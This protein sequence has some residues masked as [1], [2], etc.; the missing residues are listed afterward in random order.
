[1]SAA[2]L[3]QFS[4]TYSSKELD[5]PLVV[6]PDGPRLI[7]RKP[8]SA[9]CPLVAL[10]SDL[11]IGSGMRVRFTR[12]SAAAVSAFLLSGPSVEPRPEFTLRTHGGTVATWDN[13]NGGACARIDPIPCGCS[14]D[15]LE[16]SAEPTGNEVWSLIRL[17]RR[18]GKL[19]NR[20]QATSGSEIM[21]SQR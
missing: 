7:L 14:L 3:L 12:D 9:P 19:Q 18:S 21:R 16:I 13:A 6:T 8:K 11:F 4:G 5:V 20:S 10:A 2:D 15:H 1:P 17:P